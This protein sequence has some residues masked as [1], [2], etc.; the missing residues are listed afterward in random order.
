MADARQLIVAA[1]LRPGDSVG[2][3]QVQSPLGE[4]GMA[5]VYRAVGP[6]GEE[7]ALKLVR[8]EL[9]L[10][11]MFRK[12]FAREVQ[13]AIRIDHPHV[14]PVLDSGEHQGVPY[15]TQPLIRGGS[16]QDRIDAQGQLQLEV[17]VTLCLEVAKGL[18]ALHEHGLIHRDLK[19]ANVLLDEYGCAFVSDFGLAKDPQASLITRPGQAVGSLD[20]M[21]PEQ[22]RAEQVTPSADVYSLGC[23]MFEC[24]AGKPPFADRKGMQVLWAHLQDDPPDPCAGRDDLPKD[25]TWA[26]NRALEKD[27][28]S[29]PETATGYARMVQVAAGVPPLSPPGNGA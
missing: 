5:R 29:R 21:A 15:M 14:M 2:Q 1:D 24:L 26:V 23:V 12:R 9:A 13:T 11:T 16:L 8:A 20:Y 22:I 25:L 6:D 27:P 17:A 19:P 4:G 7:V 10:E 3:Y 18:G 28:A